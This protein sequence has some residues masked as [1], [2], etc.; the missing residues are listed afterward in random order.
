MRYAQKL[1]LPGCNFGRSGPDLGFLRLPPENVGYLGATSSFYNLSRRRD[2]VFTG[3]TP[4]KMYFDVVAGAIDEHTKVVP[5]PFPVSVSFQA[6]VFTGEICS[7]T[8][9]NGCDLYDFKIGANPNYEIPSSFEGASGGGAW[10]IYCEIKEGEPAVVQ[11][12]LLGVLFYQSLTSGGE[13]LITLHGP[14]S[15]YQLLL[16]NIIEKFP[17]EAL[18]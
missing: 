12:R 17:D 10:R 4:S 11:K 2:D 13:R 16:E 14:K 18:S 7:R 5:G 3:Q 1:F 6:T 8:Y 15:V 9:I